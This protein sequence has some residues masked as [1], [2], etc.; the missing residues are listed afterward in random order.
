MSDRCTGHC[1][2][3]FFL[4]FSYNELR[5]AWAAQARSRARGGEPVPWVDD[6][7]NTLYRLGADWDLETLVPRLI[8]LGAHS[9]NPVSAGD[10]GF[11]PDRLGN[12][13]RC[14]ALQ[15]NGDCGIY[16]RRPKLC[17][18]YPYGTACSYKDCSWDT[19]GV[20]P[21]LPEGLISKASDESKVCDKYHTSKLACV[22]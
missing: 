8:P 11:A 4:P 21:A 17:A 22:K 1:C 12:F 16:A 6:R 3:S 19:R 5:R 18:N 14:S 7:G 10:G 9:Q 13:Y 20:P 2:R 15:P